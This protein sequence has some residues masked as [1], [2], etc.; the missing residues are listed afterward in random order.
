MTASSQ[1]RILKLCNAL[2]AAE[3]YSEFSALAAELRTAVT[4]HIDHVRTRLAEY[5]ISPDRRQN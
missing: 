5:P 2:I 3:G 4:E 1:D